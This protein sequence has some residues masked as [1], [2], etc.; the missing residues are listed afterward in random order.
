MGFIVQREPGLLQRK[1]SQPSF[2]FQNMN[3]EVNN[4]RKSMAVGSNMLRA[5]TMMVDGHEP[6]R[7]MDKMRQSESYVEDVIELNL[8]DKKIN[9]GK[10]V[11]VIADVL[12]NKRLKTLNLDHNLISEIGFQHLLKKLADHPSLEKISLVDNYLDES[13]FKILKENTKKL[14]RLTKFVFDDNKQFKNVSSIK[15]EVTALRKLGIIVEVS[16]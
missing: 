10:L 7:R 1:E 14:R 11:N 2:N 3:H 5:S 4:I 12:K 6:N 16:F 13:V 8:R 9:D 15:K